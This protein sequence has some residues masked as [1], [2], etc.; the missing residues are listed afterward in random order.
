MDVCQIGTTRHLIVTNCLLSDVAIVM[1]A[2]P[3]SA[4]RSPQ[5]IS[6]VHVMVSLLELETI[7]REDFTI[8]GKV[9]TRAISHLGIY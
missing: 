7:L 8:T 4:I 9:P 1:Y 6:R 5:C 3:P 2:A